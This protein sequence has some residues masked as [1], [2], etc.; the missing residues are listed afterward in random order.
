MY[1]FYR[2]TTLLIICYYDPFT[3]TLFSFHV[4]HEQLDRYYIQFIKLLTRSISI[5]INHFYTNKIKLLFIVLF[6]FSVQSTRSYEI[7]FLCHLIS[8]TLSTIIISIICII[9][10]NLIMFLFSFFYYFFQYFL[11][12]V[13]LLR[14]LVSLC[15]RWIHC[16]WISLRLQ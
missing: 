16:S 5:V 9:Q 2:L 6:T 12:R 10:V 4:V 14:Q 3:Y 15:S 1:Y 11:R 13:M 7:E 8:G